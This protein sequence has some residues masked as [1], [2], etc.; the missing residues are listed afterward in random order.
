LLSD[1]QEFPV[2]EFQA[3]SR[4]SLQK[5]VRLVQ[6][7]LPQDRQATEQEIT[8]AVSLV[9]AMQAG[10]GDPVDL[11]ALEREI[12]ARVAVWQDT[13]VGIEDVT[14]HVEWLT[15]AL[16][17]RNWEFWERY[18]RYLQDVRVLPRRV[19]WRLDES[20]RR[21]L[22]RLE[23]PRRPGRW[24][25]TGL[26]VGQVQSGKTGN[27][28]GLACRAADAGYKLIVVLAGIHNSLRSQTQLRLDE[29][30]LGF[31]TQYQQRY[32]AESG[33]SR[34]G[35]G[36]LPAAPRLKIAS[37]TTSAESGDFRRNVA[38][39]MNLPI[40]DY[41]VVL[42]V[43]KHRSI[44]QNLRKW[45]VEVEGREVPDGSKKVVR[46]VPL[47][48]ID[49]EADH[50]SIDTSLKDPEINP[51]AINGEIREL[52]NSFDKAAY[53]GYT[54]T[55]FANIYIDPDADHSNFGQDLFPDSFIEN[56]AAPSN[57]F[58]PE[59]VFGLRIEDP[60]EDDVEPL[61]VYRRVV[62]HGQWM[63]D[64]HKKDWVP[65]DELPVSLRRALG[66]FV[67]TCAARRVRGEAGDHNS[68][69]IHVTRYQ[70]VQT[71]VHKQI[72]EHVRL[73]R[74]RLRDTYGAE[75]QAQLD[76]LH[77][78]WA[79]D[80]EPTTRMFPADE[81][82]RLTWEQVRA[83]L[84]P[85]LQKIEVRAINGSSRDA[86]EYYEHR[87]SGLSVI[88]V[89]GDKLS[90]GLTLE[91]L[92]ISYYLRASKA[93]DT[94]LQMG[95]WFGYR[96]SYEDL[97]RLYTTPA[98]RDGYVEITAAD[99]DLRRQ[100]E[101]MAA[102]GLTPRQFGLR[103]RASSVGLTVTATNKMRRGEMV[104]LSYSGDIPETVAFDM[105]DSTVAG[106]M[107]NLER[108]V[109]LLDEASPSRDEGGSTVWRHVS[110][111][112]VVNGF[113]DGYRVDAQVHRVRP[114]FIAEYIRR[115]VAVGELGDWTVR[116]VSSSKGLRRKIGV[117]D[118]GLVTRA[119]SEGNRL[120]AE[121]RYTIR[122]VLSPKDESTDLD[123]PGQQ[124]LA[125]AATRRAAEGKL[126]RKTGQPRKVPEV[127]TGTPLRGVRGTDQ[128]LLL[129]Y[130]LVNPIGEA[131][132]TPVVGFAISFPVSANAAKTTYVVNTIWRREQLDD[133][134]DREDD[135]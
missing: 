115:C 95:R 90:R 68:M 71:R 97:C 112:L 110:P 69:L 118:V 119:P 103:V 8:S 14:D 17:G 57:Y 89:G 86:L 3:A 41:P 20:V 117:H 81:A 88:A 91:G 96:P 12:R 49:D 105:K 79:D 35:V 43:K 74:D 65:P 108:F 66:S 134:V 30:L 51:S 47:L 107:A 124:A 50:A 32:D 19:V 125:L 7:A 99:D 55:P 9:H 26:V 98:L 23:D 13:S 126:D 67:L 76:E 82:S 130:P 135:E 128:A 60:D 72:D 56:L 29:G 131:D 10:M 48:V 42:V 6:A 27:Y 121:G 85:A 83:E 37:L 46:D 53:V 106:N 15:E 45:I 58:G 63:P 61:P 64:L 111:D 62:D 101:E 73:I 127:P 123:R 109:G 4:E 18:E 70:A 116:L 92:S 25:R 33:T 38:S 120:A 24:R 40:G 102:L 75:S 5:A 31:D 36:V 94:L 1:R 100:F 22:R 28:I 2:T 114:A 34:I 122:R 93:Y 87:R 21:I 132:A 39:N 78:L 113:L 54:A 16:V 77:A 129:I 11:H 80:F 84:I 52:L 59:R 104:Q 133:D 44:L